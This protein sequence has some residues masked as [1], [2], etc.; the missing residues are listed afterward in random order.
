MIACAEPFAKVHDL[1]YLLTLCEKH[2]SSLASLRPDLTTLTP[3]A[4]AF[5][6]P[7]MRE[8]DRAAADAAVL[9]TSRVIKQ[10]DVLILARL[11][12]P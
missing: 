1:D 10:V 6:Y 3:F 4:V 9:L 7:T 12:S 11:N 2:E 5:R 8:P